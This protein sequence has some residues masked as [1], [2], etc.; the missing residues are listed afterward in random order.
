LNGGKQIGKKAFRCWRGLPCCPAV[1]DQVSSEP[2]ES[3]APV[4]THRFSDVEFSKRLRAAKVVSEAAINHSGPFSS[5][6]HLSPQDGICRSR[7]HLS[8]QMAIEPISS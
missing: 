1:T 3:L 4:I 6:D 7:W 2:E 5:H 8:S